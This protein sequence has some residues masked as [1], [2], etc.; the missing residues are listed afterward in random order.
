M[1]F[2]YL[3]KPKRFAEPLGM[4]SGSQ[5]L[6]QYL[7]ALGFS[8]YGY[9]DYRYSRAF[10]ESTPATAS[11]VDDP[12]G[13]WQDLSP[14]GNHAVQSGADSLKPTLAADGL[15]FDGGD[16]LTTD[17]LAAIAS[18]DDQPVTVI[19]K[20]KWDDLTGVTVWFGFGNSGTNTPYF[21][22]YNNSGTTYSIY[23]QDD[24]STNDSIATQTGINTTAYQIA[25]L[26]FSGTQGTA[27]LNG[28]AGT[29]ASMDVGTITLDRAT[30]GASGRVAYANHIQATIQAVLVLPRVITDAERSHINNFL[31]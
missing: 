13:Y 9:Y 23:R 30:I 27:Y 5:T 3:G 18:G 6:D 8:N 12:V 29:P 2:R 4:A 1:G 7:Q 10:Q 14:Y 28:V 21:W 22:G 31:A 24:T 25:E 11:G 20:L 26:S 17:A 15:S 16:Y 19:A